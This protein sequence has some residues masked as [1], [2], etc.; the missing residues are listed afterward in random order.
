MGLTRQSFEELDTLIK[1][2]ETGSREFNF[3][4]HVAA[5]M[6]AKATQG[7]AQRLYRGFK[8]T[9][10]DVRTG[11]APGAWTVPVR[12]ITNVAY[13]GWR[14][15]QVAFGA[16]EVFSESR[17]AYMVEFGISRSGNAIRR[18][19]L[20]MSGVATLRMIQRTQFGNRIMAGTFGNL[21]NN[22]G[23]FRSFASRMQGSNILG[24]MA[25]P[26]GY[27]P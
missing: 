26:S 25:G 21:R 6:L 9:P 2:F 14:V 1:S 23:H 3:A 20:R 10:Y 15:R 22:K 27:L 19:I 16:W 8:T 11:H 5:E 13:Q 24:G 4:M 18:P 7:H 17:D 12:R